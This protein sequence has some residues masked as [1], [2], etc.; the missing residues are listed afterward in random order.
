MNIR[1]VAVGSHN[2][3]KVA[4]VRS[5]LATAGIDAEVVGI[6][7]PSG[8]AEQPLSLAETE[9]GATERAHNARAALDAE[10]GV[11]MEG[12]VWFDGEGNGWLSNVVV[13]VTADGRVSRIHGGQ[14]LLPPAVATRVRAGEELGPVMDELT[15]VANSKQKL[16][17]VGF[18]TGGVVRRE[19]SFRDEVGRAL[20]P[21]LH[22]ELYE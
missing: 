2:P 21:L 22:P 4:A 10:W 8:V 16:G 3:V 13:I 6:Q 9:R 5:A 19:D 18:L 7:V 20:A 1:T 12:G 17:A 11:G 15:G 14:V